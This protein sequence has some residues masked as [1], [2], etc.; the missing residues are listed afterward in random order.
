MFNISYMSFSIRF[1]TLKLV[2]SK[3]ISKKANSR[4]NLKILPHP[5]P[6]IL[7]NTNLS[8]EGNEK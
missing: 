1:M 3:Y 8:N 7:F 6:F 2:N 5:T 4:K